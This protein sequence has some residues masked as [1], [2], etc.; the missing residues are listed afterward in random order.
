[1]YTSIISN[2]YNFNGC[3]RIEFVRPVCCLSKVGE[4]NIHGNDVIITIYRLVPNYL[5]GRLTA[6]C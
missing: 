3:Q 5:V 1:M 2:A 6:H 4:E